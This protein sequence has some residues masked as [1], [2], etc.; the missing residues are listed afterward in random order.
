M[1]RL[2]GEMKFGSVVWIVIH[3]FVMWILVYAMVCFM[4][5]DGVIIK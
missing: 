5:D 1:E 2:F 4:M 3:V